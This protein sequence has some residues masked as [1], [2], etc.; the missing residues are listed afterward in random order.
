MV[1]RFPLPVN[2]ELIIYET[3][4]IVT[5]LLILEGGTIL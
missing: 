4:V 1:H 5:A 2:R 3:G